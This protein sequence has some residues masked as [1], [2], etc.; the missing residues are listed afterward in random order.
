MKKE[1]KTRLL[2]WFFLFSNV[3]LKAKPY[4]MELTC[5]KIISIVLVNCFL[6]SYVYGQAVAQ[7][8]EQTRLGAQYKQIFDDFTL[9]Y[10]YGKITNANYTGSDIVVIN[11]QDLHL[12]PQVQKNIGNIIS[13]FDKSYGVN[14][15][16]LEGA[17]GQLDTSWLIKIKNSGEKIIDSIFATGMLTGAEY[18]SAI[19]NRT[20]LIKGLENKEPYLENLKRF[21]DI[22][23]YQPEILNIITSM[24]DDIKYLKSL[25][26]N[27]KQK[28]AE[29]IYSEYEFLT[30]SSEK[31]FRLMD[32][33]ANSFGIDI[34]KYEN[35]KTYITLLKLVREI[36]YD[37]STSELKEFI[38]KL[39]GLLPYGVYKMLLDATANFN[40]TDKLYTYLVKLA[41]ENSLDLS[42]A[43]PNLNKFLNYIEL[44]QK[45]NSLEMVK[46]EKNLKG[47]ISIALGSDEGQ[48]DVAFLVTFEQYLKDYLTSKITSDDYK[49]YK[50]N[51]K[52]FKRLWVKYV[53]NKKIDMLERYEKI[54][55]Q[56]Y[57]VNL[58]RN[59]YFINNINGLNEEINQVENISLPSVDKVVKSLK[60]AKK[61]YIVVTGGFHTQGVSELLSSK[62]VSYL[63]VTPNVGSGIKVAQD[64]YYALAKE[65]SKI[66]FQAL[67]T[68][69][70]SEV[71]TEQRF[72]EAVDILTQKGYK[73]D[74][75]NQI[76]KAFESEGINAELSGDINNLNQVRLFITKD[77][78]VKEYVYDGQAFV[79]S[80]IA[81][82]QQTKQKS[83]IDSIIDYFKGK[84]GFYTTMAVGVALVMAIIFS[85][86]SS[87]LWFLV[88][89][90]IV[91]GSIP[92][93]GFQFYMKSFL[94]KESL[95]QTDIP[96]GLE[97]VVI[98]KKIVKALPLDLVQKFV[99]EA[100][101]I[102]K[103][104]VIGILLD[105][106]E[107][108]LI[109]K[110]SGFSEA[111]SGNES[112]SMLS[113]EGVISINYDFFKAKFFDENGNIINQNLLEVFV[114]HELRRQ[115]YIKSSD[116]IKW[117]H[118]SA[119]L[120]E[121]M[122]ISIMDLFDFF[123]VII[124]NLIRNLSFKIKNILSRFSS[125]D[126]NDF[127]N[128]FKDIKDSFLVQKIKE[129]HELNPQA[130]ITKAILMSFGT[131]DEYVAQQLADDINSYDGKTKKLEKAPDFLTFRSN[132]FDITGVYA[133]GYK[134]IVVINDLLN[135]FKKENTDLDIKTFVR[136]I[137]DGIDAKSKS[138]EKNNSAFMWDCLKK[139]LIIKTEENLFEKFKKG[140]DLQN[141]LSQALPI[142]SAI[143]LKR[144]LDLN[145]IDVAG[146]QNIANSKTVNSYLD[147]FNEVLYQ[148]I[149]LGEFNKIKLLLPE[150]FQ[151]IST[152]KGEE[153]LKK[154]ARDVG[155]YLLSNPL[156]VDVF[157]VNDKL[158]I[159]ASSFEK[160]EQKASFSLRESIIYILLQMNPV[161]KTD[162][163]TATY[164]TL[165]ICS[166]IDKNTS[167]L[168][169]LQTLQNDVKALSIKVD[170][171]TTQTKKLNTEL[172][173]SLKETL[174][175]Q[176]EN[177]GGI[178]FV[179]NEILRLTE[180][181]KLFEGR[182]LDL[183]QS[184]E[185]AQ[186]I[187]RKERL[188]KLIQVV[189]LKFN[190]FEKETEV[191]KLQKQIEL[192][193]P[194]VADKINSMEKVLLLK[195]QTL[196]DSTV[197]ESS[198]DAMTDQKW[199]D[200]FSLFVEGPNL[201]NLSIEDFK[202]K[203]P[204][205]SKIL[206]IKPGFNSKNLN[207]PKYMQN[208][209]IVD[210][211]NGSVDLIKAI[212]TYYDY[213]S[214]EKSKIVL[215]EFSKALNSDYLK[216][217]EGEL[218]EEVKSVQDLMEEIYIDTSGSILRNFKSAVGFLLSK[219]FNLDFGRLTNPKQKFKAVIVLMALVLLVVTFYVVYFFVPLGSIVGT[220]T[221]V[222]K[223]VSSYALSFSGEIVMILAF[224]RDLA[225]NGFD[226]KVFKKFIVKLLI[227]A[228]VHIAAI[229]LLSSLASM[230]II[231][232]VFAMV[233]VFASLYG[234]SSG[235]YKRSYKK[236]LDRES[237]G[238][239]IE[240]FTIQSYFEDTL[241]ELKNNGLISD[242]ELES[243]MKALEAPENNEFVEFKNSEAKTMVDIIFKNLLSNDAE[244]PISTSSI[245]SQDVTD[246]KKHKKKDY[247]SVLSRGG[248]VV[249][250][251]LDS[252]RI[253]GLAF[254]ILNIV[255]PSTSEKK[256]L[257]SLSKLG[258]G[259]IFIVMPLLSLMGAMWLLPVF[260]AIFVLQKLLQTS[261][262]QDLFNR[263]DESKK[264]SS[265]VKGWGRGSLKNLLSKISKEGEVEALEIGKTA[266][267]GPAYGFE[268]SRLY[269][270]ATTVS[271]MFL[272]N[273]NKAKSVLSSQQLETNNSSNNLQNN[274]SN[275]LGMFSVINSYQIGGFGG[276]VI[277]SALNFN[278]KDGF[279]GIVNMLVPMA[280]VILGTTSMNPL[281]IIA[282][283]FLQV[284]FNSSLFQRL[285]GKDVSDDKKGL[286]DFM[287]EGVEG[288][289]GKYDVKGLIGKGFKE[290]IGKLKEELKRRGYKMYEDKDWVGWIGAVKVE[291]EARKKKEG[292]IEELKKEKEE[293]GGRLEGK[294]GDK[295]KIEEQIKDVERRIKE[296]EGAYEAAIGGVK[297]KLEERGKFLK[298]NPFGIFVE[299]LERIDGSFEGMVGLIREL[300]SSKEMRGEIIGIVKGYIK[301]E[302]VGRVKGLLKGK[303]PE[304][305]I[306]MVG[307]MVER[308][309]EMD[310]E[311]LRGEGL[312]GI[313]SRAVKENIEG[314]KG[315]IGKALK[316]V[317]PREEEW[318]ELASKV[319]EIGKKE[320]ELI[321]N[322]GKLIEE[323]SGKGE[324]EAEEIVNKYQ[325]LVKGIKKR[326]EEL[327]KEVEELK[328][329]YDIGVVGAYGL[330]EKVMG[331]DGSVEG[332]E[333]IIRY[334]EG[335]ELKGK[336]MG[337]VKGYIRVEVM[338]RVKEELKK[339][340]PASVVNKMEEMVGVVIGEGGIGDIRDE[341]SK[342]FK[343][344]IEK[345]K[346][347]LREGMNEVSGWTEEMGKELEEK[348]GGYDGSAEGLEE[349][350]KELGE[351]KE[352]RGK[353]I[354]IV[355]EYIKEE[356]VVELRKRLEGKVPSFVLGL[357]EGVGGGLGGEGI[358]VGGI[359]ERAAE[360]LRVNAGKIEKKLKDN[361][362][363]VSLKK[364]QGWV[365]AAKKKE[366]ILK[367]KEGEIE[368]IMGELEKIGDEV[369]KKREEIVGKLKGIGDKYSKELEGLEKGLVEKGESEM[370]RL[371]EEV[372]RLDGSQESV[373]R[374]FRYIEGSKELGGEIVGIIEGY[375]REEILGMMSI[376]LR[377][378]G[379]LG[380]LLNLGVLRGIEG[381]SGIGSF[382]ELAGKLGELKGVGVEEVKKMGSNLSEM[383][384]N[385][386]EK[387]K[388]LI[389]EYAS[390]LLGEKV[391]GKLMGVIDMVGGERISKEELGQISEKVVKGEY[392]S[393]RRDEEIVDELAGKLKKGLGKKFKEEV[394]KGEGGKI[395]GIEMLRGIFYDEEG[396]VRNEKYLERYVMGEYGIEPT[397]RGKIKEI[398]KVGLEKAEEV[399]GSMGNMYNWQNFS[400]GLIGQN[401]GNVMNGSSGYI[402]LIMMMVS[403]VL[404][405][406]RKI[407][408]GIDEN[409]EGEVGIGELM[410][411]GV[412]GLVDNLKSV[413]TSGTSE[414]NFLSNFDIKRLVARKFKNGI[415]ELK[416]RL[417]SSGY[418]EEKLYDKLNN[419]DGTVK[420][421]DELFN[422]IDNDKSVK[423]EVGLEI[424]KYFKDT[425]LAKIKTDLEGRAPESILKL[426]DSFAQEEDISSELTKKAVINELENRIDELVER[427]QVKSQQV[428]EEVV[429]KIGTSVD[430]VEQAILK[431]AEGATIKIIKHQNNLYYRSIEDGVIK[432]LI[433]MEGVA[434]IEEGEI[435]G[436]KKN[437]RMIAV[438][439]EVEE[440]SKGL[441]EGKVL[442][443]AGYSTM[444]MEH[445]AQGIEVGSYKMGVNV[446]FKGE[447]GHEMV[448]DVY[449]REV[450]GVHV[451]GLKLKGDINKGLDTLVNYA[452]A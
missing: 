82:P 307:G 450:E 207:L 404:F 170:D 279:K 73:L 398:A 333:G 315:K 387:T 405:I 142:S 11:I 97:N 144:M 359:K 294:E 174:E 206:D 311:E 316:I 353:V 250:Q 397:M 432:M 101:N 411:E 80:I 14:S 35:I 268:Q 428:K 129:F 227:F 322:R 325:E 215:L 272:A 303:V 320:K 252:C 184:Y 392:Y 251:F 91:L 433:G 201:Y 416:I 138:Y 148:K 440:G 126:L 417:E 365:E 96:D 291:E 337:V 223:F 290:G 27:S 102:D 380:D 449:V 44:S 240:G 319:E 273:L 237:Y 108:E 20:D 42:K 295:S 238:L 312:R 193:Q 217:K 292:V 213:I 58:N 412:E 47:E 5:A 321:E 203:F 195:K 89:L 246:S 81:Q 7:V 441:E 249:L 36:N 378:M 448:Y 38:L 309:M 68:S 326:E 219:V 383:L 386:D 284:F 197:E 159:D 120:I 341:G 414:D 67:A 318:K 410:K 351:G 275:Y 60:D 94:S 190:M 248:F 218:K 155:F 32:K 452:K 106:N 121:S 114:R 379:E 255:A 180:R 85:P 25:Y 131:I 136:D 111:F 29:E 367:E 176:I 51:I 278:P 9:P 285:L 171:L 342:V 282:I 178:I 381:L 191:Q 151:T 55:N 231:G 161:T 376:G 149:V 236:L 72:I 225:E 2:K 327:K 130:V 313:I 214:E 8:L 196:L 372:A 90:L 274:S 204:T 280:L 199:Q 109:K 3:K 59:N 113:K 49:Y 434:E 304:E 270:L 436:D 79:E 52:K 39:R 247:S 402:G 137:V 64:A 192:A 125:T 346:E 135:Y 245:F 348:I 296:V 269:Q 19:S 222:V 415:S 74:V 166:E 53:D 75:I 132:S 330:I 224:L 443:G 127:N 301:E 57:E 156:G 347:K 324:K 298:G 421:L 373:E 431:E 314:L 310:I 162:L 427:T 128:I 33:Y 345:L 141:V 271:S 258:A 265:A 177:E 403:L 56:F 21:G 401:V 154:I 16:Y 393:G 228:A 211:E 244:Y 164:F 445:K 124:R 408:E 87:F 134:D 133:S 175:K 160:S 395:K 194:K 48:K 261:S 152:E 328:R 165:T 22:L 34:D 24:Y 77:N 253:Y 439:G 267:N 277:T 317:W 99:S 418:K 423:G 281:F 435:E 220:V 339:V 209:D 198:I 43:F 377:D 123:C 390:K 437:A 413:F 107:T 143:V 189:A 186:L 179:N 331:Y 169:N 158:N 371:M 216:L 66:L 385:L 424:K 84:L 257:P 50:N 139:A 286:S 332:L 349:L 146:M 293:L 62:G 17:Y 396:N 340:M 299:K 110:I 45:I 168:N 451:I 235:Q 41:R 442:K 323:L 15:V 399:L 181:L 83:L 334:I 18:Y 78:N 338:G 46:E 336:I 444:V 187:K 242:E 172:R 122:F 4:L 26:Y 344:K 343:E 302:V 364:A 40:E 369:G 335:S 354:G 210:V 28:K 23:N 430:N 289:V 167:N 308:M 117:I 205:I 426:L 173:L 163:K 69:P 305:V 243:W 147:L 200:L 112:I 183:E 212:T 360:L 419:F 30:M 63:V 157:G 221:L 185:R 356:V 208:K 76:L 86:L 264:I 103:S 70:L 368:R 188:E 391:S 54:V 104:R 150:S 375:Y 230:P 13:S 202:N 350:M 384:G 446:T 1:V 256:G 366:E 233:G 260:I 429:D 306:G 6:L 37:K 370:E 389:K 98:F 254:T 88:P 140:E 358:G 329:K 400:I 263:V 145:I 105:L 287:K 241:T 357:I 362:Y 92:F 288:L 407:V 300:E 422:Y 239:V 388:G 95:S 447:G 420:E 100:L 226:K 182:A 10:S 266:Y 409:K 259:F 116:I 283:S 406:A 119:P 363:E 232:M 425:V 352:I 31:Y 297:G 93:I 71:T 65:Q 438:V 374:L 153:A 229:I 118:K 394:G 12:H 276:S 382:E 355:K 61:I 361:G 262:P 234:S 115:S